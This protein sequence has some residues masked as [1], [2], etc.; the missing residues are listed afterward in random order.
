MNALPG[1]LE[2]LSNHL[3]ALLDIIAAENRALERG[4]PE[5][6]PQLNQGKE[7]IA[8]VLTRD[9][10]SLT[11]GLGLSPP[12]SRASLEHALNDHPEP[13]LGEAWTR[14]QALIEETDRLN[15]LN[16]RL[17]DEQ[18][19]RTRG[20]IDI[21]QAAASQRALYGADGYSVDLFSKSREIDE[22]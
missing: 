16:G 8:R 13:G 10:T 18:L 2:S 12:V 7:D 6:L 21:L 3:R 14:V 15:R 5:S 19:R 17:I 11:Q 1:L 20:A 9:W 4:D 22:A